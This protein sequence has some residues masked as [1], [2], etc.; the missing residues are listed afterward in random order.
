MKKQLTK[1]RDW[2]SIESEVLAAR[3]AY[4][5]LAK[6]IMSDRHYD[7]LERMAK[8]ICP[9]N[10]EVHSI[11]STHQEDY[12]WKIKSKARALVNQMYSTSVKHGNQ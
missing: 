5:I 11:G 3:Y 12:P 8:Q 9:E 6:P 2:K 1:L 10:S 4:Y 7:D